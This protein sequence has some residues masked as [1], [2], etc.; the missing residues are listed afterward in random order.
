MR[1]D[2]A[3]EQRG[4]DAQTIVLAIAA[5][6]AAGR[7]TV[8]V[9]PTTAEQGIVVIVA[10]A[11]AGAGLSGREAAAFEPGAGLDRLV[12]AAGDDVD[13]A[14]DGRVA[15][16]HA[17]RTAQHLDALHRH[18]EQTVEVESAAV[19]IVHFHAVDQH[20]GL[21]GFGAAQIDL[22]D[23]AGA[24][25]AA[26][27]DAGHVAQSVG[28]HADLPLLQFF[29]GDDGDGAAGLL[30]GYRHPGGGDHHLR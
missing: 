6:S 12:G 23:A 17:L 20:Q 19:G 25:A 16:Q 22:S 7:P 2:A 10:G 9:E 29:A 26:N 11:Q 21:V 3:L 30:G 28:D 1:T 14:A 18:I 24:A 27:R 4:A 13:D 15:P 5:P 8:G